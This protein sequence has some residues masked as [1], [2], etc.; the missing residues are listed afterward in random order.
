MASIP[1]DEDGRPDEP[2]S[3]KSRTTAMT[4]MK[5]LTTRRAK[6]RAAKITYDRM[7]N[8]GRAEDRKLGF[9]GPGRLG[10]A[11]YWLYSMH[12]MGLS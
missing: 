2:E 8:H 3:E 11:G 6:F 7:R 9:L 4:K 5:D 12:I 1:D 10:A